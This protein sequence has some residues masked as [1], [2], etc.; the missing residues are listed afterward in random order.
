MQFL[1]EEINNNFLQCNKKN[2]SLSQK[3]SEIHP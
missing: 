3:N 1:L 2:K